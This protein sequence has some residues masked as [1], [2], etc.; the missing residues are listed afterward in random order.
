MRHT[1]RWRKSLRYAVLTT[2]ALGFTGVA[3][4]M[5]PMAGAQATEASAPTTSYSFT[6]T[7][8]DI[9]GSG[10]TGSYTTPT[11]TIRVTGDSAAIEMSVRSRDED[12]KIVLAAPLGQRLRPGGYP[13]VQRAN[14]RTGRAPGLDV[15]HNGRSCQ[16]VYGQYNVDQIAFDFSGNLLV[17]DATF[18]QH[19][20]QADAPPLTGTIRYQALPLGYRYHSEAGDYVGQGGSQTY[21]GATTTFELSGTTDDV[22]L[23]VSGLRDNWSIEF[24][25]PAGQ[26]LHVGTYDNVERAGVQTAGRPGLDVYGDGRACNALTGSFTINDLVADPAG[27]VLGLAATFTQRCEGS[28]A[29]LHGDI[30]YLAGTWDTSTATA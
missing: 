11:A 25:P 23:M 27:H 18:Q 2:A 7:P 24:M 8:G 14:V 15:S 16:V 13:D 28:T 20:E 29:T 22:K 21:S 3:V 17:L 19:C 30:R 4:A 5:A 10:A 1:D 26:R 6:S 9:V 12:W